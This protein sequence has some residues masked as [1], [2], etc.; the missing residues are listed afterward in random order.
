MA[1][2]GEMWRDMSD[3]QKAPYQKRADKEKALWVKAVENYKQG[4]A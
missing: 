1:K 3:K 4:A 2:F